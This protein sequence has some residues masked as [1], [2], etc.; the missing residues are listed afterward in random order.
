MLQRG[1]RRLLRVVRDAADRLVDALFDVR[2]GH[3]PGGAGLRVGHERLIHAADLEQVAEPR[4]ADDRAVRQIVRK[5]AD[6][7]R[8]I[9][10][11]AVGS[12]LAVLQA[13]DGQDAVL[14]RERVQPPVGELDILQIFNGMIHRRRVQDAGDAV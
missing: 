13:G 9:L 6:G 2:A 3:L 4:T 7:A 10:H 11:L 5:D 8:Q 14:I 1:D 12:G